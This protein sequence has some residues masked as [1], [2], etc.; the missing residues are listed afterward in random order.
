MKLVTFADAAGSRVG[1]LIGDE[2]IDLAGL[3]L[4]ADMIAF[5]EAGPR[6]LRRASAALGEAPRQNLSDVR[7][8]APIPRPKRNVFCVGKNY[9]DHAHEF[10]SSGFDATA[11]SVIPDVP[12]LFTKAPSSVIGPGQRIPAHLDPTGSVD[13]E[14]ELAVVIGKA[15]RGIPKARAHEHVYGYTIINDVTARALQHG[16][17]QWFLGKSVDGFCPMGPAILTADEVP[18]VGTLRLLTRVNGEVRQDALV[19]DLIFDIPTLIETLSAGITMEP[20]DL[21]A[22]GTPA[23]VGIGFSP[24]KYLR[25]GDV[26]SIRIDPIGELTNPVE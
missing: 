10:S 8:L 22:T 20:G 1:A 23:G 5:I 14:G 19:A 3:D 11:S 6:A 25:K 4:P 24:P 12:I 26:V 15:G 21:V 16:H 7:L 9:H 2:V 13:Y 17:K 18:D